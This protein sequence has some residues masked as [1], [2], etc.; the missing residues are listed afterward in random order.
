MMP[1]SCTT[2]RVETIWS[3]SS[4]PR[5]SP[6]REKPRIQ[7]HSL[8]AVFISTIMINLNCYLKM[9]SASGSKQ[10]CAFP[11]KMPVPPNN[12]AFLK[13]LTPRPHSLHMTFPISPKKQPADNPSKDTSAGNIRMGSQYKSRSFHTFSEFSALPL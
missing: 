11:K 1:E 8:A 4:F 9:R 5:T 7:L 13:F 10:H 2:H 6:A 3:S 12:T